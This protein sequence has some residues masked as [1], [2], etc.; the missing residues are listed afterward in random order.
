MA[1]CTA[2]Y[3]V[4][5]KHFYQR[6]AISAPPETAADSTGDAALALKKIQTMR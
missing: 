4:S 6:A 5:F 1:Y 3:H 2:K